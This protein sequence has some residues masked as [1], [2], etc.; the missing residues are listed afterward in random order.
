MGIECQKEENT[1]GAIGFIF[2][3][4]SLLSSFG[5]VPRSPLIATVIC[6]TSCSCFFLFKRV[7]LMLPLLQL[8]NG[9]AFR[10]DITNMAE[11]CPPL[12]ALARQQ[13][14]RTLQARALHSTF[15]RPLSTYLQP[16]PGTYRRLCSLSLSLLALLR[17]E[18][19]VHHWACS[20]HATDSLALRLHVYGQ[21]ISASHF[22]RDGLFVEFSITTNDDIWEPVRLFSLRYGPISL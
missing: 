6:P 8:P 18:S 21:I 14:E 9:A 22:L 3:F 13:M 4:T 7:L 17:I 5:H 12:P 20:R 11:A 2:L 1:Q 19:W 15:A 10:Y 16:V